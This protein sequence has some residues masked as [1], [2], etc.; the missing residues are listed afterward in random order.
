VSLLVPGHL[1]K[2][3]GQPIGFACSVA[4]VL[5]ERGAKLEIAI[6]DPRDPLGR[7]HRVTVDVDT[8]SPPKDAPRPS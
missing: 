3:S 2:K 8:I 1:A 7:Q 5:M 4:T 6:F